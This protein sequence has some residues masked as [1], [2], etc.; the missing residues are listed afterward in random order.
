M[1]VLKQKRTLSVHQFVIQFEK[2]YSYT[3]E[4]LER[5]AKRRYKIIA[6]PLALAMN[7]IYN[8][9][10][11]LDTMVRDKKVTL[12]ERQTMSKTIIKQLV[13]LQPLLLSLWNIERTRT[14]TI[15]NWAESIN[16]EIY[17]VAK[18]GE[19]PDMTKN[20]GRYVYILDYE[21]I[22]KV[23]FT[24]NMSD[25]HRLIHGKVTHLPL[26]KRATTGNYLLDMADKALYHVCSSNRSI[27]TNKK[28]YDART[29]H[30]YSAK[31]CLIN[32]QFPLMS[33]FNT[34]HYSE[35][36]MF[37]CSEKITSELKLIAGVISS[38]KKRF[39]NL[40]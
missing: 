37:E 29:K 36:A 30:L 2:L 25:L 7:N 35:N 1:S 28:M 32:M 5:V 15:V 31:Q 34:E 6:E 22:N 8:N 10:M 3:R 18:I 19:I 23:E 13:D 4:R 9:I 39:S 17:Y 24:K 21:A 14:K 33:L 12:S 16:E 26:N 11:I 20:V 27:P 38:D 40:V